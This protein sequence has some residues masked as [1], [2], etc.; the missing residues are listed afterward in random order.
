MTSLNT[1]RISICGIFIL[2]MHKIVCQ[3]NASTIENLKKSISTAS[4]DSIKI[5][6]LNQLV[7]LIEDEELC[8]SYNE[9]M[10]VLAKKHLSNSQGAKKDFY[11]LYSASALI[12]KG[13]YLNEANQYK[14][15]IE[16]YLQAKSLLEKIRNDTRESK[17]SKGYLY[18]NLS[19]SYRDLGKANEA[20]E[21]QKKAVLLFEELQDNDGM[22]MAYNNM[23]SLMSNQGNVADAIYYLTESLR[24]AKLKGNENAIATIHNNIGDLNDKSGNQHEAIKNYLLAYEIFKK[25]NNESAVAYLLQNIGL[26]YGEAGNLQ[27]GLEYLLKAL[28]K[29]EKLNDKKG[30]YYSLSN[31]GG[32]YYRYNDYKLAEEYFLKSLDAANSIEYHPGIMASYYRLGNIE[33][34]K[35]DI[36]KARHYYQKAIDLSKDN[37]PSRM[38]INTYNSLATLFKNQHQTD[39]ALQL[40]DKSIQLADKSKFKQGAINALVSCS[41]IYLNKGDN[42]KAKLLAEKSLKLSEEVGF[43]VE[44]KNAYNLLYKIYK[45]EGNQTKALQMHELYTKMSD[46]LKNEEAQKALIK[47]QLIKEYEIIRTADSI[48]FAEH[49]KKQEILLQKNKKEL[50]NIKTRN[51]LLIL[52]SIIL[53]FAAIFL[54]RL[55]NNYAEASKLLKIKNQEKELL[56]QEIHHRVKNNLQIV[57]SLLKIPQKQISDENALKIM[58]DSRQRI[59]SVSLIHKI[60]YEGNNMKEVNA[61][62]YFKE[63]CETVIKGMANSSQ[64]INLEINVDEVAVDIDDFVPM[65]L[66]LNE[67][68]LNSLKYAFTDV[69]EPKITVQFSKTENQYNLVYSDNGLNDVTEKIKAKNSF[70]TKMIYNLAQQL[71]G[72]LDIAFNK[73]TQIILK[74]EKQSHENKST[75]S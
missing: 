11:L 56:M 50:N 40:F 63:L 23:A 12:N 45:A 54:Y 53:V 51:T 75:N 43:I 20:I 38:L 66:I 9:Q 16:K 7:E 29:F 35:N 19:S 68:L 64:H 28:K 25:L 4:S 58:D 74:F 47:T 69:Q 3:N 61:K 65:A 42:K 59:H 22:M 70:G 41:E 21:L 33:A 10:L 18:N 30:I 39:S 57:S 62:E 48:Q 36:K 52:I 72:I 17:T 1:I 34:K 49:K 60:L 67:L 8:L 15:A 55:Y 2:L 32:L 5:L 37:D 27:I 31:I 73:G 13:Y 14:K 24:L 6:L 46:S 44:L 26:S 71:N